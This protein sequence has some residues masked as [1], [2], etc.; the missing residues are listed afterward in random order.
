MVARSI[1]AGAFTPGNKLRFMAL[2]RKPPSLEFVI[3]EGFS[4][5]DG[6][7]THAFDGFEYGTAN[8]EDRD[9]IRSSGYRSGNWQDHGDHS[10]EREPQS[11][12]ILVKKRRHEVVATMRFDLGTPRLKSG[13]PQ[14]Q[15]VAGPGLPAR[16]MDFKTFNLEPFGLTA[17]E[18]FMARGAGPFGYDYWSM[19]FQ[20]W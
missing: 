17:L 16:L 8:I 6:E 14:L 5:Q 12:N 3:S 18:S 1:K 20:F 13:Q 11:L 19:I 10:Q 15:G 4:S 2:S 9:A 7:K